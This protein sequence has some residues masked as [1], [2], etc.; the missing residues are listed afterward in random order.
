M[1]CKEFH[2]NFRLP[3]H[4]AGGEQLRLTVRNKTVRVNDSIL[5]VK[6]AM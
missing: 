2:I 5:L 1:G 3:G 6:P 4:F